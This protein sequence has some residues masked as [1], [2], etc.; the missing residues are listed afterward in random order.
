MGL[1]LATFKSLRKRLQVNIPAWEMFKDIFGCTIE[2]ATISDHN[3]EFMKINLVL[4]EHLLTYL[5]LNVTMLRE[6][7][8]KQELKP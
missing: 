6:L 5:R 4:N 8:I 3:P 1:H 7:Q 2:P